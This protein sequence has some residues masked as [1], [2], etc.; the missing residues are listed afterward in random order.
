MQAAAGALEELRRTATPDADADPNEPPPPVLLPTLKGKRSR[1]KRTA[2]TTTAASDSASDSAAVAAAK[3]LAA[4]A[5]GQASK[6]AARPQR[7]VSVQS[8]AAAASGSNHSLPQQ[9]SGA[10]SAASASTAAGSC[11]PNSAAAGASHEGKE[12]S[13]QVKQGQAG[14]GSQAQGRRRS[15][16]SKASSPTPEPAPA[17]DAA[18]EPPVKQRGLPAR[19]GTTQQ[20]PADQGQTSGDNG[21]SRP[22][23]S[24]GTG[25]TAVKAGAAVAIET[26]PE[27]AAG[28]GSTQKTVA[29][30]ISA[31][32][33]SSGR[34]RAKRKS[35]EAPSESKPLPAATRASGRGSRGGQSA[36][37]QAE[38]TNAAHVAPAVPLGDDSANPAPAS[39]ANKGSRVK[40]T[41]VRS[42]SQATAAAAAAEAKPTAASS[43]K[44]R[45]SQGQGNTAGPS[46]AAAAQ[47]DGEEEAG[48]SMQAGGSQAAVEKAV[49]QAKA[50]GGKR[51]RQS[52]A[53]APDDG[54]AGG[55]KAARK[56]TD[57]KWAF[58]TCPCVR[59]H[60]CVCVCD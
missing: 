49:D 20:P 11:G 46:K 1:T 41:A 12:G 60:V 56:A 7:R 40:G 26:G 30:G 37:E 42:H 54:P 36:S 17:P 15:R 52:M 21:S 33:A 32:K 47:D 18:A 24:S 23:R 2:R 16:L 28:S 14:A 53:D 31:G 3:A 58:V 51:S 38:T 59:E 45:G 6:T 55:V 9:D 19:R 35:V 27:Q 50:A 39:K 22:K 44:R 4:D 13:E 5:V 29:E 48:P 43:R 8:R 34:G 25:S 10:H 57:S